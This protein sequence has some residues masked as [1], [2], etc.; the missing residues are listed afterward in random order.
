MTL[1]LFEVN[2][3]YFEPFRKPGY[4][5]SRLLHQTIHLI[6]CDLFELLIRFYTCSYIKFTNIIRITS[7]AIS[8]RFKITYIQI[9]NRISP[10]KIINNIDLIFFIL[11]ITKYIVVNNFMRKKLIYAKY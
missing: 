8:N 5:I 6:F 3:L 9:E 11:R 10:Y 4:C 1:M 7:K 2:I